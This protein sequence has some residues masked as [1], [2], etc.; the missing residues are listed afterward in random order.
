VRLKATPPAEQRAVVLNDVPSLQRWAQRELDFWLPLGPA[1]SSGPFPL[2]WSGIEARLRHSA[3]DSAGED[4][5][6][7]EPQAVLEYILNRL[8]MTS[9]DPRSQFLRRLARGRDDAAVALTFLALKEPGRVNELRHHGHWAVYVAE[10]LAYRAVFLATR[11]AL[12]PEE[13]SS[14]LS[15]VLADANEALRSTQEELTHS[16]DAREEFLSKAGEALTEAKERVTQEL[17][18]FTEYQQELTNKLTV[19]LSL[20][21]PVDYWSRKADRH[22]RLAGEYRWWFSGIAVL[23]LAGVGALAVTWL[24]PTMAESESAWWALVLFSALLALWAWPLRLTSKLYLAHTHLAEDA[25]ERE[26]ITKTF[27]SLGSVVEL[28]TDDRHLL[29]A[30]LFRPSTAG[31]VK[32]EGGLSITDLLAARMAGSN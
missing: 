16:A 15:S 7:E 31:L 18:R 22:R 28:S 32:D 6:G 21:A 11:S 19:Q 30:A 9:R 10:A 23:G 8:E 2:E 17:T 14:A 1:L 13:T 5:Q 24:V 27:L 29:L 4:Y 12:L 25:A 26:V 20:R 3:G